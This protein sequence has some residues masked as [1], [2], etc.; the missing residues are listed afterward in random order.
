MNALGFEKPPSLAARSTRPISDSSR[1]IPR[2]FVLALVGLTFRM[3]PSS[4]PVTDACTNVH[5]LPRIV[6]VASVT[7]ADSCRENESSSRN[8]PLCST[9]AFFAWYS[10]VWVWHEQED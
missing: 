2:H 3:A 10:W 1:R 8:D 7:K 9:T 5:E 6:H 4:G